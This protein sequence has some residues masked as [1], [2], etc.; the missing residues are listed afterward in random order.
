[1]LIASSCALCWQSSER[2]SESQK[3][4]NLSM[5]SLL[6]LVVLIALLLVNFATFL[7]IY[8]ADRQRRAGD[9]GR[10]YVAP[11][12]EVPPLKPVSVPQI[13]PLRV[14]ALCLN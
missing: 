2:L 13:V 14:P 1:M 4:P 9:R 6:S 8:R 12:I 10:A 7:L 3:S 5:I 11:Y